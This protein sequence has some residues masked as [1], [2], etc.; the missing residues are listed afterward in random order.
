MINQAPGDDPKKPR[1]YRVLAFVRGETLSKVRDMAADEVPVWP[2][3]IKREFLWALTVIAILF[4]VSIVFNAPLED[5]ADPARTPNPA[6]APWY[7]AG[8]QELLAYFD[9][10]I[11]GVTIPG[12]ILFALMAIPYLDVNRNGTGEYSFKKRGFAVVVFT[13]GI[14]LWFLLILIGVFFRGPNW[15][16]FWL[17]EEWTTDRASTG[18]TRDLPAWLSLPGLA[19]Y[20]GAGLILPYVFA[21]KFFK[22]LGF[23]RYTITLVLLLAMLGVPVKILLRLLFDVKYILSTPWFNL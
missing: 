23:V 6:K 14:S 22:A 13:F 4:A 18:V 19:A 2:D 16:W 17:W 10:W 5:M 1:P 8:L 9:P 21:R 20:F 11:A 12:I 7:F 3:L 15:A